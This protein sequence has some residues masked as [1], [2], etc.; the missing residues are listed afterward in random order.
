RAAGASAGRRFARGAQAAAAVRDEHVIAIYEVGEAGG[1]P[2]LVMEY[3]GGLSLQERLDRAGPLPLAEILRIGAQAA[4]G[5]A[6]AHRQGL[7]APGVKPGPPPPGAR[8]APGEVHHMRAG[9]A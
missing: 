6:A 4:A 8:G 1:L 3:V 2:Y 5:L 7:G 9:P